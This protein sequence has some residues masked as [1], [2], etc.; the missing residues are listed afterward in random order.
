MQYGVVSEK[1]SKEKARRQEMGQIKQQ[2]W[3]HGCGLEMTRGPPSP[4]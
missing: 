4:S 2:S 1:Y 3:G